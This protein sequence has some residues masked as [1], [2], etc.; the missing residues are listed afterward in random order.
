MS[1]C[2][3]QLGSCFTQDV[4][5]DTIEVLIQGIEDGD[6]GLYTTSRGENVSQSETWDENSRRIRRR[7]WGI[8]RSRWR[9][10]SVR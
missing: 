5:V 4:E 1:K 6:V 10:Y 8:I 3:T 9:V 7:L 2:I